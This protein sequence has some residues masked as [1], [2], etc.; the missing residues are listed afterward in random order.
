METANEHLPGRLGNAA[1]TLIED[2]RLDPRLKPLLEMAAEFAPGVDP[3]PMDADYDAALAYVAAFEDSAAA[4]NAAAEAA[5][6]AFENVES[7]TETI[8]GVDGN[9]IPLYIHRP[10]SAAGPC[11]CIVHIHGGGM[12]LMAAT[13]PM[14]VRWRNHLADLGMVV[15]GVEFRNGG[16]ALGPHAFPAGLNDCASATQWTYENRQNLGIS[17]IV[18]SGE[19]GGGNLSLATA[20]KANQESWIDQISGVYGMCP[21]IYGGYANPAAEILSLQEN[22]EYMLSCA[23]MAPM[24][25]VYDPTGA[26]SNNPL[27]WPYHATTADLSGLPPHVISVNELD[28]LRDEGLAYYRKLLA[29][30]VPT[31]GRTVHGTPHGGD[32]GFP[33][34]LPEVY[35]ATAQALLSF[36]KSLA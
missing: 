3:I 14:F 20:L 28:P 33:D 27:A 32:L 13:D 12:V 8:T 5:M 36:A 24:V 15:V 30:G 10:K 4:G 16:G 7:Y 26:N 2:P 25:T 22:D 17:S 34:V 29:A 19:S 6:P 9:E 11:P 31:A 1:A 23:T 35:E 21:Y 18:L